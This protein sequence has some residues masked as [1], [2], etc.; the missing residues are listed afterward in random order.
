MLDLSV[1]LDN[2]ASR[3][4]FQ[5][6]GIFKF[7]KLF[8]PERF[9]DDFAELHYDMC[10]LLFKLL[11][12]THNEATDRNAYFL[13][14]RE[15]AKTTVGTFL[16]PIYLLYLKGYSVYV[17][18]EML[19]KPWKDQII[20][21]PINERFIMIASATA[22]MAETFV[23]NLRNTIEARA[24]LAAIFGEKNPRMIEIDESNIRTIDKM[25]RKQM[26]MTSDGTVIRGIGMGQQVR[27]S[28]VGGSRPTLIICDDLYSEDNVK[29]EYSRTEVRKWFFN[30]VINS[31][32]S[33]D[34]KMLLLGT[35]VHPDSIFKNVQENPMWFGIERPIVSEPE[36]RQTINE[37]REIGM[38]DNDKWYTTTE[39]IEWF[40]KYQETLK[41][42]SWVQ[43]HSLRKIII[44]Y[45]EKMKSGDLNWF[46]QEHMNIPIA[47]EALL[48][49]EHSFYR[50]DPEFYTK[51]DTQYVKFK[52][53]QAI[54]YGPVNLY[55]GLDPASS[56]STTSDD[57][58]ICVAG[59][60]YCTPM[61]EGYS[62]DITQ[63]N[64][65]KK[66]FP[67]IAHIEG[68]KYA[69]S[70]YEGLP[71]MVQ[72]IERIA[73]RF[74]IQKIKVETMGTQE[75]IAREIRMAM[76]K[77]MVISYWSNQNKTERVLSI[78]LSLVQ[79]YKYIIC[80]KNDPL[81]DKLFY[82]LLTVGI[83]DHDDYPDA[84]SIALENATEPYGAT[85]SLD[86]IEEHTLTRYE[87]L[88]ELYGDRAW[89]YL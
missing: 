79:R 27:G 42:L 29:T 22:G 61:I 48:V 43:R 71:G 15:A 63:E 17:R 54:W 53:E 77:H 35:M 41:T 4:N 39:C 47:P 8:F 51:G 31:L 1:I 38:F 81:I 45:R 24:D 32:D 56:I 34:G 87:Q 67:I 11:D 3:E 16:F 28:N 2:T 82:Q 68:G 73:K 78:I 55:V 46:Y 89:E 65:V 23:T 60:A 6:L 52:F 85:F 18:G 72:A 70:D 50:T 40:R 21:I 75:Q 86:G 36:L 19:D 84:L 25:W 62:L 69:I 59:L 83:A 66:V 10:K 64:M 76:R 13:V 88:Y 58:V 7:A 20:E 12:P 14:H 33:H 9:K 5:E 49:Q 74:I 30:A 80:K 57:T 44:R 26:F 37:L